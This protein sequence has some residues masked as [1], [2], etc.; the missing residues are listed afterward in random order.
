MTNLGIYGTGIAVTEC[1]WENS[2]EPCP[3]FHQMEATNLAVLLLSVAFSST[4]IAFTAG[5]LATY[6]TILL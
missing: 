3:I 4:L 1:K 6:S 5:E 2:V